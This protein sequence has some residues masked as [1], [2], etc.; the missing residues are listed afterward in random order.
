MERYLQSANDN[1]NM[2]IWHE[3]FADGVYYDIARSQNNQGP[4]DGDDDNMTD[5]DWDEWICN[6]EEEEMD[7]E[8]VT[9]ETDRRFEIYKREAR[10]GLQ[11]FVNTLSSLEPED[12]TI[13]N[14]NF[15]LCRMP[16]RN[17]VHESIGDTMSC[18]WVTHS[19][20]DFLQRIVEDL[21]FGTVMRPF[22]LHTSIAGIG[23]SLSCIFLFGGIHGT[24]MFGLE[25]CSRVIKK[26]EDEKDD[27][28]SAGKN[29][30]DEDADSYVSAEDADYDS[31]VSDM[32]ESD[33]DDDD[34]SDEEP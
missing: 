22:K 5:A 11:A 6:Q 33:D 7:Y 1:D 21:C 24:T 9:T 15:R 31:N 3:E 10:D 26:S 16:I 28:K 27:K 23:Y 29:Q 17:M 25:A 14:P 20:T 8:E 18:M 2:D 34:N 13:T 30:A 19:A 4:G 12:P 32:E